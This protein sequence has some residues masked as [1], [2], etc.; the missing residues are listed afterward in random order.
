V[1]ESD[2]EKLWACWKLM[3]HNRFICQQRI[4]SRRFKH[5]PVARVIK[6][7]DQIKLVK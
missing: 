2:I 7:L 6:R 4:L 3:R 5:R 1:D